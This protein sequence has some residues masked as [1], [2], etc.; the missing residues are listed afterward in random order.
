MVTKHVFALIF[1]KAHLR[2]LGNCSVDASL[3]ASVTLEG[4]YSF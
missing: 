4:A 1:L 2:L 3:C